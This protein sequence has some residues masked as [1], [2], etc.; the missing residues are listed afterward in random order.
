MKKRLSFIYIIGSLLTAIALL[1]NLNG[2][3]LGNFF[4]LGVMFYLCTLV[5]FNTFFFYFM[6]KKG[7]NNIIKM[8]LST[9]II[10]SSITLV[11][12][13]IIE[14]V[15]CVYF[16]EYLF[17]DSIESKGGSHERSVLFEPLCIHLYCFMCVFIMIVLRK[18]YHR[19]NR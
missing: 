17:V 16:Y 7:L 8:P 3:L 2:D 18:K 14:K 13:F 6:H 5:P 19:K 1:I 12:P 15:G 10:I 9:I 4:F 11:L